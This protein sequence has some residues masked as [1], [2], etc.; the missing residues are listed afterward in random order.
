MKG[1]QK[2]Y[3][4]C[5]GSKISLNQLKR[6]VIQ[7][8]EQNFEF[9]QRFS[10]M[11][12]GSPGC[13]KTSCI[14][15][16]K[17][18]PMEYKGKKYDGIKVVYIPLGQ[19]QQ[20]GD[21]LGMPETFVQ[22][23]K[24]KQVRYVIK[25]IVGQMLSQGWELSQKQSVM[26]YSK[27]YWV[28]EQECPGIIL[29]DDANRASQ[30]ILKG[31]MQLVQYYKT[32]G[33]QIPKG[34]TIV[35]TGNPDNR[36]NQ[37]CGMDQAQLTRFKHFTL[38]TSVKEWGQWA[39]NN[40][41]DERGVNYLLK[42]PQMM[43]VGQRTN[44]RTLSEFF[45]ILKKRFMTIQKSDIKKIRQIG[46]SLIDEQ[47]VQSFIVFLM[48]DVS[49]V[50]QPK[51]I[52]TDIDKSLQKLHKL[53]NCSQ[54]RIDIVNIT[55]ERLKVYLSSVSYEFKKQDVQKVQ[56]WILSQDL[57][58]DCSYGFIRQILMGGCK[59]GKHF[60]SGNKKILQLVQKTYKFKG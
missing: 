5:Y 47:V 23:K 38:Q 33:W 51:Q 6:Y 50:I 39:L 48:R 18:R 37:V 28:P 15:Q 34:W 13:G 35:F 60:I 14:K 19:I 16:L 1:I 22:V 55:N 21:I 59:Y 46:M 43:N 29:F 2:K 4:G 41:V 27:P 45:K 20:M 57:P 11:V 32:I 31:M 10:V 25:G 17:D 54:P 56:K 12:W 49:L 3:Q 7:A 58:L 42:Y 9:D 40:G 8:M 53:M 30:R 26:R 44:L 24:G 36:F 52:L